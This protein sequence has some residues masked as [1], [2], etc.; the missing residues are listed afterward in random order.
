MFSPTRLAAVAA[1]APLLTVAAC[2]GG[3][4]GGGEESPGGK[5]PV[6]AAFYALAYAAEQVGGEHVT[7]ATLTKPGGEPHDLELTPKDVVDLGRAQVVVYQK[8]FQ[9]AVDDAVASQ[10]GA[11]AFDVAP[12]AGLDL[13]APEEGHEGESADEHAGHDHGAQDPHFWLDPTKYATVATAVGERLAAADTEH[14]ADYRANAKAFA[15]KL[16]AL[17]GEFKAGL[18]DC[19]SRDLV[20]GHAAFGYLAHRYDLHQV[21]IAGISP[22][23]EPDAAQMK[24]LVAHVKEAKVGTVYAETLVSPALAQTIAKEGGAQVAVLDPVEAVT[25]K[26]AGSDYLE[27]MRSNLATLKKGQECG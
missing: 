22:D 27:I 21:G 5:V 6:S 17:D 3:S 23:A 1:L 16:T 10:G 25:D 13:A 26:S 4:D 14:A 2:G 7:V 24:D 8:G 18:A 9:P 19:K 20:T 12:V 11:T 15:A